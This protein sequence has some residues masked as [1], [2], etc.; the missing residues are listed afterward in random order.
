MTIF[1]TSDTHFGHGMLVTRGYRPFASVETMDKTLIWIWNQRVD[2]DDDVYHLGDFSWTDHRPYAARLNGRI[3]LVSGNH[4]HTKVRNWSGWASSQRYLELT[5]GLDSIV[6]S[7][8]AF[9]VWNKSHYGSLHFYGHSHAS[10]PGCRQSTDVGVD[11]PFAEWGPVTL[12]Q[13]KV[14]LA[15][16]E[17]TKIEDHHR[18]PPKDK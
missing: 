4:D 16:Q 2:P 18:P 9:R 3:H 15:T 7:H 8:Y 6:L 13:I 12:D 11:M 1:F 5:V 14:H 10:L 17:P